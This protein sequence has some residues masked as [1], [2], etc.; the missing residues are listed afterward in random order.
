MAWGTKEQA[1]EYNRQYW[2]KNKERIKAKRGSTT[3]YM[4]EWREK[5][6]EKYNAYMRAYKARQKIK[7]KEID[8]IEQV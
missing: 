3:E 7:Q 5:N 8:R 1:K 2:Q 6:R 4:R